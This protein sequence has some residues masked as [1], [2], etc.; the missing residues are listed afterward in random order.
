MSINAEQHGA[1]EEVDE[2]TEALH[3]HEF[4]PKITARAL[5]FVETAYGPEIL[6]EVSKRI[7]ATSTLDEILG[8]IPAAAD[9]VLA[10]HYAS[11]EKLSH[12]MIGETMFDIENILTLEETSDI[13]INHLPEDVV[14]V[15]GREKVIVS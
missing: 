4:G 6:A 3:G 12:Q 14:F 7:T 10:D 8:V 2:S 5:R 15:T 13:I 9:V 1:N 11:I